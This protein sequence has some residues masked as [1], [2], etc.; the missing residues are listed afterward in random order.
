[1]SAPLSGGHLIN[2]S[3]VHGIGEKT[4]QSINPRTG[5]RLHTIFHGA[6][7]GQIAQTCESAQMAF[8]QTRALCPLRIA[9]FLEQIA[10]EIEAAGE[11]LLQMAS[12]ESGLPVT[13][14]LTGERAR[15]CGQLRL[16][17]TLVREGSWVDAR[18]DHGDPSRTPLPKPDVRSHLEPLGP[19]TVFDAG[20]FPL[21]F[22][23]CGGDTASALAAG[24]P[25]IVKGHT[26]HPGTNEL[27]ARAVQMALEKCELP[28]AFFQLLQGSGQTVGTALV[29]DSRIKAVGFTGSLSGGRALLDLAAKRPDPIPVYAEMG[30]LN[31]LII[32]PKAAE[33]RWKQ[34]AEGLTGALTLGAG[35]FCTRPGLIF[36]ANGPAADAMI[37]QIAQALSGQS[38]C[39]LTPGIRDHFASVVESFALIPGVKIHVAPEKSGVAGTGAFL[40]ETDTKTFLS[41]QSLREEAF[42]PSGIIVR[43]DSIDEL[44]SLFSLI[45]GT[46]TATI[47][48]HPGD[49]QSHVKKA[50]ALAAEF[51]GRI[52]SN[53]YPTG[54]EVCHAMVHGGPYPATSHAGFT[55]VGT[56]AIRRFTRPV[57]Y[58]DVPETWL[59]ESLRDAN[60]RGIVRLVDGRFISTN[61]STHQNI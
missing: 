36:A 21:A 50:F 11:T 40:L 6:T 35:Q 10:S 18:I 1:M 30:S 61:H 43:F 12:E 56:A 8:A 7:P 49:D 59:P 22:G 44:P 34:I 53:G 17:A 29:C 24:C 20:N 5:E 15:T 19:V 4:F 14:R 9:E 26:A 54:V 2:G 25:V 3:W 41:F 45:Q 48:H 47:H 46:L 60:P 39:L 58:Q 52:I 42:G 55:S 31:P 38:F 27:V 33:N 51:A 32:L 13:P 23:A 28:P 16:F 57:C 37:A